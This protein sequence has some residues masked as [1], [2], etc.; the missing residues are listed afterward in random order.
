[1]DKTYIRKIVFDN[2]LNYIPSDDREIHAYFIT[3]AGTFRCA[4]TNVDFSGDLCIVLH[5]VTYFPNVA[6]S[7]GGMRKASVRDLDFTVIAVS[8]SDIIAATLHS[9]PKG[10][11]GAQI[12]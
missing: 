12:Y 1:M 3:A 5:D 11:G 10:P 4:S 9:L 2:A 7:G 8:Y 6:A